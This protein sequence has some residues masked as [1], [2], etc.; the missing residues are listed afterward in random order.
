MTSQPPPVPSLPTYSAPQGIRVA[1]RSEQA[2]MMKLMGKMMAKRLPR[3]G[4]NP[5]VHSQTIKVKHKKKK[6][7]PVTYW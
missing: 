5:N 3:L 6:Y 2:P 7:D 1:E 4:K